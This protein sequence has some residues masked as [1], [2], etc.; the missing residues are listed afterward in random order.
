MTV[1]W[2]GNAM[3]ILYKFP[4]PQSIFCSADLKGLTRQATQG[5]NL[6]TTLQPAIMRRYRENHRIDSMRQI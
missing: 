5:L 2:Q 4:Q 3:I 1:K 6:I